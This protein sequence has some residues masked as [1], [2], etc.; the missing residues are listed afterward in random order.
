MILFNCINCTSTGKSIFIAWSVLALSLN[1][2]LTFTH[3][4][5]PVLRIWCIHKYSSQYPGFMSVPLHAVDPQ[6]IAKRKWKSCSQLQKNL[7]KLQA[8]MTKRS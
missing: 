3:I 4:S 1:S 7:N 8:V 5:E 6:C 2:I